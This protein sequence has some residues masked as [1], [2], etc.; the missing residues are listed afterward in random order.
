VVETDSYQHHQGDVS[1][2]DDHAR[3][4]ALRRLGFTVL[5]YTGRQLEREGPAIAA[6]IRAQLAPGAART[7]R[8]P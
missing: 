5:R 1:F 3:D 4:L 8:R 7:S 6:E 2:E